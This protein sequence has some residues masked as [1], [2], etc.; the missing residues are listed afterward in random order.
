MKKAL[1][2]LTG[3]NNQF[4]ATKFI[5]KKKNCEWFIS[6]C[7]IGFYLFFYPDKS[8]GYH[9]DIYVDDGDFE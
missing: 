3:K 7:L 4:L 6:F 5:L 2:V 8:V 9:A 1:C